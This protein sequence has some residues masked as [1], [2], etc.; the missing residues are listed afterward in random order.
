MDYS[1][2]VFP[3]QSLSFI[4]IG[5]ILMISALFII[6]FILL[7]R[8]AARLV[9]GIFGLLIYLVFV[10]VGVEIVTLL[11]SA[12]PGAGQ[13]LL[14]GLTAFCITRSVILA[15]LMHL[16]R[17]TVIRYSDRNND[18]GLGDAMMGGLGIALSQAIVSGMELIYLST[19]GTTINN[20]GLE[21]L[22]KDT[23]QEEIDSVMELVNKTISI[24]PAYFLCKGINNTVDIIFQVGACIVIYAI[25]KRGLPAVSH[26]I[27]IA[28]NIALSMA[29]MFTDYETGGNYVMLTG[30]KL[31]V[32][33]AMAV[34]VIK[35]DRD[36]LNGEL[37]SFDNARIQARMPKTDGNLK[38]K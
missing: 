15:L 33:A 35:I 16:T 34:W 12:L 17:W 27:V 14:G 3:K 18:L 7:M 25:V 22:F 10:V 30:I 29:S 31:F 21:A 11:I 37:A 9:P 36:N 5:G 6:G 13:L 20:Y 28:A 32:T 2:I 4:Y 24:E 38:N 1:G 19:L 23:A 8:Y 26:L